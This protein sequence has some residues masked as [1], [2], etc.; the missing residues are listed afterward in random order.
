MAR[1]T[2]NVSIP[3]SSFINSVR[4]NGRGV[5]SVDLHNGQTLRYQAPISKADEA[6]QIA[7]RQEAGGKPS[8]GVWFN[9]SVRQH[10]PFL[11][12]SS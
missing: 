4:H 5:L 9:G 12:K 11:G 8:M 10:Y 2:V 7:R 3:Q 6:A 1:R